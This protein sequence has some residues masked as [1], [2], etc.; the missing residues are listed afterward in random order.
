MADDGLYLT[1]N[2]Q[3]NNYA[4]L[5]LCPFPIAP[6]GQGVSGEPLSIAVLFCQQHAQNDDSF[7]GMPMNL[8]WNNYADISCMISSAMASPAP[9]SGQVHVV[10]YVS[11]LSIKN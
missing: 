7:D 3:F 11:I 4:V 10:L 8:D 9:T 1:F 2:Y 6:R 5:I